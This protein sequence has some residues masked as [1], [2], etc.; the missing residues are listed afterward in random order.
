MAGMAGMADV[1]PA[2]QEQEMA[3]VLALGSSLA[4]GVGDFLGGRVAARA[5][6]LTVTVA[7]QFVG[8]LF[9]LVLTPLT[10]GVPSSAALGIGALAGVLG[11]FGLVVYFRALAIGPMGVV[12]P[13]SGAVG[14]MIPVTAGLLGGERV[15]PLA[16]LGIVAGL[17]AVVL[18][19]I[20]PGAAPSAGVTRPRS[21]LA[22]A[23]GRASA[24]ALGP[25]LALLAGV[26][27]G[28]FFVLLDRTP[29]GSG[30]WPLV[31][32][33]LASVPLL[34]VVALVRRRTWPDR[35]D[36]GQVAASGMLDSGA[37]ALFLLATRTGLLTLTGLLSSLYPVV[38]VVLARQVLG[39]RLARVQAAGV[40]LALVAVALVTIG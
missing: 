34:G 39:D 21:V 26:M 35:A 20:D 15:G 3:V 8:L 18:S 17:A 40:V 27:F 33:R 25:S 28:L 7:T 32:A 29:S 2:R 37:N 14:A 5:P 24:G 23:R 38:I 1:A 22:R 6:A 30:L 13:L 19:T 11:G 4:W 10:G 36:A 12:A 9:V 16:L 31:G